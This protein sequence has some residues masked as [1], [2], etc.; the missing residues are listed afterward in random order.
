MRFR[1]TQWVI[2]IT[3]LS[4]LAIPTRQ[5]AAQPAPAYTLIDLGTFGGPSAYLDLPGQTMNAEGTLVGQADS[6]TPDPYAPNCITPDCVDLVGFEWR[7]GVKTALPSLGGFNDFPVSI[8]DTGLIAGGSSI[9]V[10]D[11]ATGGPEARAVLWKDGKILD[12]GTLPGGNESSAW[13]VN[14]QG[15]VAGPSSNGT[16]DPYGCQILFCWATQTRGF[17]WRNGVMKDMGTLGG[18]DTVPV[19]MD[20]RGQ[21]AGQSYT[22]STPNPAT[23]QPTMDPFLWQDGHMRDLGSLGGTL[24]IPNDMNDFGEVVGQGN[25]SGDQSHH[26]FLWDGRTLLDLGTLGGPNGVANWINDAGD[27]VGLADLKPLPDGSVRHYGFLWKHGAMIDL[28]PIGTRVCSSG[29]SVNNRDQVVGAEGKCHGGLD[30]MLW[31][32]GTGYTLNSLVAPTDLHLYE[33]DYI[34]DRGEILAIGALPNGNQR[35]ALL[36]PAHPATVAQASVVPT[37]SGSASASFTVRFDSSAPGQGEVL[38]GSG[39]GCSGMVET[40]TQ[41]HGAASTSHTVTVTGNDLSGTIGDNGIVPGTTYWV[42]AHDGDQVRVRDRQQ[43]R[44]VLQRDGANGVASFRQSEPGPLAPS[45]VSGPLRQAAEPAGKPGFR[46]A[47]WC[48]RDL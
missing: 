20:N 15:L 47:S 19:F 45:S 26:P 23:G 43:R 32:H 28:E 27:V 3:I 13:M 37:G 35:V 38:F 22:S 41:D 5:A 18:P 31:D 7:D 11:P 16:P 25:L 1:P 34:N 44:P 12:L 30:A 2:A 21:I 9:K 36:E 24:A 33:A 39:P 42:R 40:A 29:N 10:I 4:A 48:G 46:A 8:N 14:D 17:V 6:S